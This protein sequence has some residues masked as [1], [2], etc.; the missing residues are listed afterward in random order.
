MKIS[1]KITL[2]I[3]LFFCVS[4]AFSQESLRERGIEL[5]EKGDYTTAIE[6]LQKTVEAD[7]KDREAHLF[8]GMAYARTDDKKQARKAFNF[9]DES[10]GKELNEN[11]D[12]KLEIISKPRVRYTQEARRYNV[13]GTV[14]LAVEFGKNGQ[15]KSVFP[16]KELSHG[17]TESA[18]QAAKMIEFEPAIKN[19][20]AVTV[21]KFIEYG[22][23]V[24]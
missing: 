7:A 10:L 16:V 18:I 5:Y 4:S 14:I 1:Y 13:S 21:I 24:F 17:L 22:F 9:V 6:T 11:Y 3:V 2:F 23:L 12:R 15:I 8:L 19:G 20:R